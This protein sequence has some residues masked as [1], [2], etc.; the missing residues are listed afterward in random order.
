MRYSINVSLQITTTTTTTEM[1]MDMDMA[2]ATVGV[3]TILRTQCP[4]VS[5]MKRY[6]C[7]S[8]ITRFYPVELII[9]PACAPQAPH[10]HRKT[11]I[12]QE[13]RL[14]HDGRSDPCT[15]R[16]CKQ[17]RCCHRSS[18]NLACS[19]WG[20]ILCRSRREHR[21]CDYDLHFFHSTQYV[22]LSSSTYASRLTL[23]KLNNPVLSSSKVHHKVSITMT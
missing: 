7:I 6:A 14:S 4:L 19:L 18:S 3:V 16:L 23:E 5:W 8:S 9:S 1:D 15:R 2:T 22:D 20:K 12:S 13:S 17:H 10:K 11:I 21:H